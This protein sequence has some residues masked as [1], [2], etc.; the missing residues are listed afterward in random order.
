MSNTPHTLAEEFPGQLAE[1]HALKAADVRFARILE[2]YD[3]VND[4]IHNAETKVVP[5]SQE[6][7]VELRKRRLSLK[8]QIAQTLVAANA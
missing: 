7:E 3:D 8:D 5:T 6:H 1:I 4:K 2:E